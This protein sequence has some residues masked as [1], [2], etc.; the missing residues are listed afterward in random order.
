[1]TMKTKLL[2]AGLILSSLFGYLEWGAGRHQFLFQAEAEVL[3]KLFSDPVSALHP[4]TLLPLAGQLILLITLFQHK[5]GKVF[6]LLGIGG[7]A[8]LLLLLL[9]IGILAR[10][11]VQIGATLPFLG[12]AFITVRHH[13]R[14][15]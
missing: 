12:L 13:L 7:L 10:N 15:K 4:L 2:H 5:P 8:L 6:S 9:V 14:Q 3:R 1:M 11:P